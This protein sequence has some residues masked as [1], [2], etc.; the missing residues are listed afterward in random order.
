[1]STPM[2]GTKKQQEEAMRAR[3]QAFKDS[4]AKKSDR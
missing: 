2:T 3:L 4:K 1:M